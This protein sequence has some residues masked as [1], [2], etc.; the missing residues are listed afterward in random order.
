MCGIAGIIGRDATADAVQAMSARLAHRGR[1][2]DVIW[3]GAG[4]AIAHRR[5][6]I[7]D[8]SAAGAQPMQL[9]AHVL[10]YNGELY[11]FHALRASLAVPFHSNCDTEVLLHL[12]AQEGKRWLARAVG[13][14]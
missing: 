14:C 10:T 3:L 2:A 7:L 13:M 8:L 1:D 6:A 9:G 5:L 12:L 4:V 11:N